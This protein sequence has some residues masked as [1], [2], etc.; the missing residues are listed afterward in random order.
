MRA[1]VLRSVLF[2]DD[3]DMGLPE[4]RMMST[5]MVMTRLW[6]KENKEETRAA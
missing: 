3:L 5:V 2:V 4:R 1:G 6:G